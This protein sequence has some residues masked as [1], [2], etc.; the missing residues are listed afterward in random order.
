MMFQEEGAVF[1]RLFKNQDLFD[2]SKNAVYFCTCW[3]N[4]IID[5]G[6]CDGW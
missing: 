2:E 3:A 4:P 1:C 5:D 6:A